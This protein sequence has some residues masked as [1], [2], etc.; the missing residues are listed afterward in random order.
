M[1]EEFGMEVLI[2]IEYWLAVCCVLFEAR[3]VT[4]RCTDQEII[5]NSMTANAHSPR[6]GNVVL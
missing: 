5:S 6:Y 1:G 3:K 2:G 4:V